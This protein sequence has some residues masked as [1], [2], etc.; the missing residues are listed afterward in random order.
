VGIHWLFGVYLLHTIGELWLSPV[1]LAAMTRLAPERVVGQMLGVWF[2][3]SSLG[4]FLGGSVA[5]YYDR[6]SL[7]TL[8]TA[9]ALSAFLMAGLM[10]LLVKPVR[11]MLREPG[12]D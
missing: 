3:A 12:V 7:P 8:L 4:N 1:G 10:F 11:R 5:G 6:L 2:L 9:V